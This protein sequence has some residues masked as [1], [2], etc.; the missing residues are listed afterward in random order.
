[1]T[2]LSGTQIQD[3]LGTVAF[4]EGLSLY[5]LDIYTLPIGFSLY[6]LV[7]YTHPIGFTHPLLHVYVYTVVR[8][9]TVARILYFVLPIRPQV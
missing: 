8:E 5:I 4:I 7:M 6:M 1:M 9:Y 2:P 3:Q